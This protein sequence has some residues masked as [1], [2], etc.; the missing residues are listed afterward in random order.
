VSKNACKSAIHFLF[1][2]MLSPVFVSLAQ[3]SP[4]MTNLQDLPGL[5]RLKQDPAWSEEDTHTAVGLIKKYL[6]ETHQ[7]YPLDCRFDLSASILSPYEPLEERRTVENRLRRMKIPLVMFT[8]LNEWKTYPR[9]SKVFKPLNAESAEWKQFVELELPRI[10]SFLQ[11]SYAEASP[12]GPRG[13]KQLRLEGYKEACPDIQRYLTLYYKG[14]PSGIE[15]GAEL[16]VTQRADSLRIFGSA[17][18]L[19]IESYKLSFPYADHYQYRLL[20]VRDCSFPPKSQLAE[21]AIED[22]LNANLD[23][24]PNRVEMG[25]IKTHR[26]NEPRLRRETLRRERLKEQAEIKADKKKTEEEISQTK[27]TLK[28][29]EALRER[30][31]PKWLPQDDQNESVKAQT[32][33]GEI[34]LQAYKKEQEHPLDIHQQLVTDESKLKTLM[35]QVTVEEKKFQDGV[36]KK[37]RIQDEVVSVTLDPKAPFNVVE[38]PLDTPLSTRDLVKLVRYFS[39]QNHQWVYGCRGYSLVHSDEDGQQYPKRSYIRCLVPHLIVKTKLSQAEYKYVRLPYPVIFSSLKAVKNSCNVVRGTKDTK[40]VGIRHANLFKFKGK[41]INIQ[42]SFY[43]NQNRSFPVELQVGGGIRGKIF[44][45]ITKLPILGVHTKI[46]SVFGALNTKTSV[47]GQYV[48]QTVPHR[49]LKM[50]V[51]GSHRKYQDG[52]GPISELKVAEIADQ[53]DFYLDPKRVTVRG[54]VTETFRPKYGSGLGG[55]RVW[56]V[57]FEKEFFADTNADGTYEIKNVPASLTK[58][59]SRDR[60]RGHDDGARS[61]DLDPDRDNNNIDLSMV[62][63]LTIL[64]GKVKIPKGRGVKGLTVYIEGYPE[65]KTITDKDGIYE[66]KDIPTQLKQIVVIPDSEN[67]YGGNSQDLSE[68]VPYE[69]NIK[70]IVVPYNRSD[71]S[72]RVMNIIT[73]EGISGAKVW[74]EGAKDRYQATTENDGSYE[75]IEVPETARVLRVETS[76][77]KYIDRP[78]KIDPLPTPGKDIPNQNFNLVP[79]E[80]TINRIVF[81]LTWNERQRDLDSQLFFPN[82]MHLY[83]KTLGDPSLSATGGATLDR[84]DTGNNGRET[85]IINIDGGTTKIPGKYPFLVYQYQDHGIQFIDSN[86]LVEVYRDGEYV[87]DIKPKAGKGRLWY[88]ADVKGR[89]IQDVNEFPVDLQSE[90]AKI[91]QS[92]VDKEA[93]LKNLQETLVKEGVAID[94]M[95]ANSKADSETLVKL[96]AELAQSKLPAPSATPP[97]SPAELKAKQKALKDQ[98]IALKAKIAKQPEIIRKAQEALKKKTLESGKSEAN[99][100]Q[101]RED[102]FKKIKELEK[103]MALNLRNYN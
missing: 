73:K 35:D 25:N 16:T 14:F 34:L 46:L 89:E 48:F 24:D 3:E 51:Y 97:V 98:M 99:L 72:G 75:L 58:L 81:V 100:K 26:Y 18:G 10:D 52:S 92:I 91:T 4:V 79:R 29:I 70:D 64:T 66:F 61:V 60:T 9:P 5:Q 96:E 76:G 32:Q 88:V 67:I 93:E 37:Y 36:N 19:Y 12:Y 82:D 17:S 30:L 2:A 42:D 23:T 7:D 45:K 62:P 71:V 40:A 11:Q 80:Y 57:G 8:Q 31:T 15:C 84:D 77:N 86:A 13:F 22:D 44:D 20:K 69:R 78:R 59:A 87:K 63:R 47:D 65:L 85:T 101:Y 56:F 27:R 39:T 28:E 1:A 102:S 6:N 95:I 54:K 49:G 74:I 90:I 83:F 103:N 94:A 53:P 41:T 43:A 21:I 50:E 68:L 38:I 55:I 33:E